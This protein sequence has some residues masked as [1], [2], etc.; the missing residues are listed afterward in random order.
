LAL[1]LAVLPTSVSHVDVPLSAAVPPALNML[2]GTVERNA[3]LARL[4]ENTLTGAQVQEL[5][6]AARPVH[7]LA[8]LAV[9]R[10]FTLATTTA[11]E[12]A[13]FTYAIDDLDTLRVSRE[14][15]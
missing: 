13:A 9:G 15:G 10:S 6:A 7:D 2:K 8:R 4:L 11:G 3:T 14:R 12:I 1:F 5:V